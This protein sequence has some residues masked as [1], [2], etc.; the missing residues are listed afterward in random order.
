MSILPLG[1]GLIGVPI[2]IIQIALGHV[3]QGIVILVGYVVVVTNIDYLLRPRLV[4]RETQI[5]R[6]LV[7][8][9]V[10]GGLKLFGFLGVIYGPVIMVFLVT[11]IEI[12][13]EYYRVAKS[14][15]I[16]EG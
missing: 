8:L 16:E 9:S 1:C 2:G 13:L 6:A 14:V 5:N 15:P 12:Y 11:T 10:F 7:L 3:W 4:S